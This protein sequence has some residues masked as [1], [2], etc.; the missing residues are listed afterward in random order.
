[1]C[2]TLRMMEIST[3]DMM[4]LTRFDKVR[5][6]VK[7][8]KSSADDG[9]SAGASCGARLSERLHL[10]LEVWKLTLRSRNFPGAG[11]RWAGRVCAGG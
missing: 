7:V 4:R 10:E 11:R 8:V 2:W 1:M 9:R 6:L 3:I 5:C